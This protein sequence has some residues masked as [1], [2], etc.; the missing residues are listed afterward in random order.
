MQ[1]YLDSLLNPYL[2][3]L[4]FPSSFE[5]VFLSVVEVYQ[6]LEFVRQFISFVYQVQRSFFHF[7][8]AGFRPELV[9]SVQFLRY[10]GSISPVSGLSIDD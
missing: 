9:F 5:E 1:A 3:Y 6:L 2:T 7:I 4:I 8:L 10:V